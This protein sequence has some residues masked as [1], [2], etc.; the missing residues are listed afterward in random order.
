MTC[1]KHLSYFFSQNAGVQL[2]QQDSILVAIPMRD[3]VFV[4]AVRATH[5][6][7]DYFANVVKFVGHTMHVQMDSG[8]EKHKTRKTRE[9]ATPV[10]TF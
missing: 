5:V 2:G 6:Y 9:E 1:T 10:F 7:L 8:D 3:Q 4:S